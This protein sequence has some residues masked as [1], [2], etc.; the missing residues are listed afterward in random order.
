MMRQACIIRFKQFS[1]PQYANENHLSQVAW[2]KFPDL[3]NPKPITPQSPTSIFR[4]DAK[5]KLG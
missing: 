3:E 5:R 1:E 2:R 4:I